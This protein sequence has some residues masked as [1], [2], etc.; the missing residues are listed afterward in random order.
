MAPPS[1]QKLRAEP[2]QRRPGLQWV[3]GWLSP[4]IRPRAEAEVDEM[5]LHL[6]RRLG[7]RG[8]TVRMP[9]RLEGGTAA[10]ILLLAE[11]QDHRHLHHR[12]GEQGMIA[13][14]PRRRAGAE[15]HLLLRHPGE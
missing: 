15:S 11:V 6:P 7:E 2:P 3:T 14:A 5:N 9:P 4:T 10:L 1:P 13:R 12:Q 8:T